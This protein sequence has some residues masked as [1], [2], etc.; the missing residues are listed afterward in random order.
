MKKFVWA[1][2]AAVAVGLMACGGKAA[3]TGG[4]GRGIT[5]GGGDGSEAVGGVLMAPVAADADSLFGFVET[6]VGFGPRN[7][8]SEGHAACRR[9]LAEMLKAYGVDTV[10]LQQAP[11]STWKGER[12]T[13]YNILGRINPGAKDRVL[14]L[15]HYDT[16]PWADEDPGEENRATPIDGANDG[17]SGVAVLLETARCLQ[18]ARPD[19]IGVDLLLVDLEDS[20]RSGGGDEDSWC[21]GTQKWVEEMPYTST[22]RPMY[23]VLLD[24][25]GGKD[26]IFHREHI[27]QTYAK[28]VVDKIWALANASGHADRFP[29]SMGGSVIDDHLY[30]NQAGIPCV[31]IIESYNPHTGS[32]N[33]TWHTTS[34]NLAA[35]DRETLRVVTQVVLNL[36]YREDGKI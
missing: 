14:L 29:N 16:R 6:Q 25:V 20:G 32:F 3:G 10:T 35:I 22:D 12:M 2:V 15:A 26:A 24:M 31:D 17:A 8:G 36:L 23:G 27:S 21:L 9:Y 33:P 7:P 5:D 13:A 18:K 19:S 11:V 30:V 1:M 4:D 34:D 28:R